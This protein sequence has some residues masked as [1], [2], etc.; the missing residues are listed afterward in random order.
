MC[1]FGV[2]AERS[3]RRREELAGTRN[4]SHPPSRS[5][6]APIRIHSLTVCLASATIRP[7]TA[8]SDSIA[9]TTSGRRIGAG[10]RA[11]S[12]CCVAGSDIMASS[13]RTTS[14]PSP[15]PPPLVLG[16]PS[17]PRPPPAPVLKAGRRSSE[18]DAPGAAAAAAA[19][20]LPGDASS[21]ASAQQL[22]PVV[23]TATASIDSWLLKLLNA[24]VSALRDILRIQGAWAIKKRARSQLELSLSQKWSA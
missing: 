19:A 8:G 1:F 22:W 6:P 18:M 3:S 24:I 4:R 7:R 23:A 11:R 12:S 5:H 20:A 2:D 14:S 16:V 10:R 15:S 9:R 13:M 17:A 21:V